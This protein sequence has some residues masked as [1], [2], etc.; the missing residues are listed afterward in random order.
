MAASTFNSSQGDDVFG[1]MSDDDEDDDLTFNLD[2]S[3]FGEE[4]EPDDSFQ[5][6]GATQQQ[7]SDDL[8]D[9]DIPASDD[10]G[11]PYTDPNDIFNQTS[12]EDD[13]EDDGGGEEEDAEPP[14]AAPKALARH[15]VRSSRK[16]GRTTTPRRSRNKK[17]QSD[18]DDDANDAFAEVND[19]GMQSMD[20]APAAMPSQPRQAAQPD[21]NA[22]DADQYADYYQRYGQQMPQDDGMQ[23]YDYNQQQYAA[24]QANPADGHVPQHGYSQYAQAGYDP[25][26]SAYYGTD[27]AGQQVPVQDN[28]FMQDSQQAMMQQQPVDGNVQAWGQPQQVTQQT[29]APQQPYGTAPRTFAASTRVS[30]GNDADNAGTSPSA[31]SWSGDVPKPDMIARIIAVSDAIRNDLSQDERN[32]VKTVMGTQQMSG[33]ELSDITYSVLTARKSTMT[34]LGE[35]LNAKGKDIASRVFYLLRLND[36]DLQTIYGIG[37]AFGAQKDPSDGTSSDHYAISEQANQA[38]STLDDAN[39]K[40]LQSVYDIYNKSKALMG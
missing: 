10:D 19:D 12:D 13:E 23:S 30:V 22:Y 14:A 28:P 11:D 29:P 26:Q 27:A 5:Q 39:V 8:F 20:A 18:D 31:T 33:D 16:Q 7:A 3:G 21:A 40:L 4:D 9:D 15:R 35:L 2:G 36:E 24:Q 25:N 1:N 17:S 37:I 32:A 34:A 38:V 6:A